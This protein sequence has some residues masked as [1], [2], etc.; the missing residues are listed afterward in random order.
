MFKTILDAPIRG[1]NV[2][3]RVDFNVSRNDDLTIS[4]DA[5]ISHSLPTLNLLLSNNNKLILVSHLGQPKVRDYRF[6]LKNVGLRLQHYLPDYKVILVSDF[7]SEEGKAQIQKQQPNEIILLENI[8]FY[9]EEKNCN[10][11]FAQK[12][13]SLA[14]VYVNDA[15]GS[16]HRPDCSIVEVPKLLP[17]FAGILLKKE[18]ESMARIIHNP[19]KP[20]VA[21]IGG[22]KIKTKINLLE[23]LMD[24]SDQILVGGALAN[25][26]LKALGYETG[27]SLIEK[28]EIKTAEKLLSLS[29][30][31]NVSFCLPKDV[32]ISNLEDPTFK[33][34]IV[35]VNQ[36]KKP[37]S[38]VDIGPETEAEFGAHIASARTLIWNGPVGFSEHKEFRHGT[39]FLYYSITENSKAFSV[40]GGGDTLAA[41]SKEEYLEKISHLSTGGGAMLEYIEKGTL[42][43][44]EALKT[45]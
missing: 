14:D 37:Y 29:R 7:L 20:F 44:I 40:V 3:V 39:D 9:P 2:L 24:L 21:I 4:D 41:I 38:I 45:F 32:V 6:S 34:D 13:A 17:S 33:T 35:K 1:K 30:E 26:F 31:K 42:P 22:A 18:I 16:C 36:V 43:G 8:R 25:N 5:R 19:A 10:P 12:L 11:E 27:N 15:F 28:D 23:K